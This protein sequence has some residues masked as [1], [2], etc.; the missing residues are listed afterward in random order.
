MKPLGGPMKA[1]LL[2]ATGAVT[3]APGVKAGCP[4]SRPPPGNEPLGHQTMLLQAHDPVAADDHVVHNLNSQQARR[5]HQLSG[6]C[7]VLRAGRRI[8]LGWLWQM[9]MWGMAATTAGRNTSAGRTIAEFTL[10][11]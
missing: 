10:P 9:M 2:G 5:L 3:V 7:G 1:G 11:W 4:A 8:P 6:Q